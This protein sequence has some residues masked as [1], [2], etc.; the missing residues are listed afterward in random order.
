MAAQ[1]I[2]YVGPGVYEVNMKETYRLYELKSE[3][4][5]AYICEGV[6]YNGIDLFVFYK[7]YGGDLLSSDAVRSVKKTDK[8]LSDFIEGLQPQEA[9]D[10]VANITK[11]FTQRDQSLPK[12]VEHLQYLT[13]EYNRRI[14]KYRSGDLEYKPTSASY[15]NPSR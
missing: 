13:K 8:T 4:P 1:N 3:K 7:P 9:E 10:C 12:D 2:G 5:L 11:C 6:N 15:W 14:S